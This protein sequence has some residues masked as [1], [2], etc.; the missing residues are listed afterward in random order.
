MLKAIGIKVIIKPD[1]KKKQTDS[2][3]LLPEAETPPIGEV[4]SIGEK[5]KGIEVGQKVLF[6]KW[7]HVELK[8][9]GVLY[10]VF[11]YKA[12]HIKAIVSEEETE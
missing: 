7:E 12:E 9:E 4:I 10:Y 5:V 2:G 8:H 3:I 11:D 1:G 6:A